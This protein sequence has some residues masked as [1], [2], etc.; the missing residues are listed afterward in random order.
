MKVYLHIGTFKTG[1]TA[2]QSSLI[3]NR[4]QLLE[5]G[6]YWGEYS[7]LSNSHSNIAYG[8]LRNALKKENMF[9][10]YEHH[11]RFKNL[12][13]NPEEVIKE[14]RKNADESRCD[15]V[16]ISNEAIFADSFRT[17]CGLQTVYSQEVYDKI[18]ENMRNEL[19]D[20][21]K[22]YFD[23]IVI[24][25]YLRRQDLFLEAQYNQFCK[26]PWYGSEQEFV[27]FRQFIKYAPISLDYQHVLSDWERIFDTATIVIRAYEKSQMNKDVIF[28][29]FGNILGMQNEEIEGFLKVDRKDA[30]IRWD[31]SVIE[32]KRILGIE[33]DGLNR[34][35]N[36]YAG[37][38]QRTGDYAYFDEEDRVKTLHSYDESNNYVAKHFLKQ[39]K[40]FIE[41]IDISEYA[42]LSYDDFQKITQYV[43]NSI[44]LQ[45]S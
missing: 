43:L 9:I 22:E 39:E 10:E 44:Y 42:G 11:P 13:D 40:L 36:E 35:L 25:C 20:I 3:L 1:S 24:V 38:L 6:I 12:A 16:I 45:N 8:L 29:F 34:I 5:K 32:Y 31:R 37:K 33:N 30:N 17:L 27:D 28:D 2:L 41:P 4:E 23:E 15:T 7:T 21:L 26:Q 19:R 14:M 18:N